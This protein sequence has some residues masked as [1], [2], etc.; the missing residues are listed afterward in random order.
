MIAVLKDEYDEVTQVKTV[1]LEVDDLDT[2]VKLHIDKAM[3]DI[4]LSFSSK[5]MVENYQSAI[6]C[7][8]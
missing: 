5:D 3:G 7:S 8:S 2:P 4:R 1:T 6:F